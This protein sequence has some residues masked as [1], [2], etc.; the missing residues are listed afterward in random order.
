[1]DNTT[2]NSEKVK[3][4]IKVLPLKN[5]GKCGHE[6]CGK[7]AQ[8]VVSGE[9][10]PS[11]CRQDRSSGNAIRKILGIASPEGATPRSDNVDA[12]SPRGTR[13][14]GRHH[15]HGDHHSHQHG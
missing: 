9:A 11:G 8:A 1:M 10:S 4:I 14:G 2:S 7:F 13:T 6:T 15:Q 12:N 5:C 3:E